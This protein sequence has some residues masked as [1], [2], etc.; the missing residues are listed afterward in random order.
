M[1]TVQIVFRSSVFLIIITVLYRRAQ[2]NYPAINLDGYPTTARYVRTRTAYTRIF[3]Y[4]IFIR[5]VYIL[6][7]GRARESRAGTTILY[8]RGVNVSNFIAYPQ[9]IGIVYTVSRADLY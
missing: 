8:Y 5:R 1:I 9:S 7:P 2:T 6:H 4:F 3:F